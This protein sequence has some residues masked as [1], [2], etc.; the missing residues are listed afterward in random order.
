MYT[1]C[2]GL[3]IKEIIFFKA[4][5]ISY[6]YGH[7]RKFLGIDVWIE[8]FLLHDEDFF[9]SW[10]IWHWVHLHLFPSLAPHPFSFRITSE[11]GLEIDSQQEEESVQASDES[12]LPST[13]Q[14]PPSSS[15]AGTG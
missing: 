12:D 10:V 3:H 8:I 15:S 6:N 4:I 7:R 5:W 9:F 14:D 11:A 13:S 1:S 2:V